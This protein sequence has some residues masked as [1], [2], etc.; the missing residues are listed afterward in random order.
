MQNMKQWQRQLLHGLLWVLIGS[1]TDPYRPPEITAPNRYLVVDG[2]LNGGTGPTVIKLLRTQNIEDFSKPAPE[3]KAVI[4]V[5]SAGSTAYTLTETDK[6]IYTLNSTLMVGR[7]YQVRIKTTDGKEYLSDQ[8]TIQ[9]TP[10]IDSVSWAVENN[11]VQIYA[12]THDPAN[13]TKYYRWEYED[14]YEIRTPYTSPY[15]Y[16]NNR[17]VGRAD[18]SIN[19]CWRTRP[20]TGIL[21]GS[22]TR[23]TE[24]VVQQAPIL[25]IPA[26]SPKLLIKYS[27]LLKQYAL[28]EAGYTYWQNMR[29]NTEQLGSLFDPLP[30]QVVGNVHNVTDSSEPVMGFLDGYSVE[31]VR[32][33]IDRPAS[34]PT[35]LVVTGYEGCFIDTIPKPMDRLPLSAYIDKD[36]A[37]NVLEDLG[38]GK[39]TAAG[40]SCTDC[41]NLGTTT[42]PSYWP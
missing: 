25:F 7:A 20:S 34:M 32:V 29:K 18:M 2:F 13:K 15:E 9:Q 12:N 10:K 39:Y 36:G 19:R 41:R 27:I 28:S 6:G 22:T 33:F 1:C 38:K 16:I 24:D 11:G 17:L 42:K 3:Q 31:Q 37:Y 30:S 26:T 23:L 4:R 14:T 5:E 40:I 35:Y 21:L 8:I